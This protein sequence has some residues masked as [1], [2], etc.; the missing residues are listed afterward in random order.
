MGMFD[1]VIVDCPNCEG[2]VEFQSKAGVCE[3]ASFHITAV[4]LEIAQDINLDESTCDYCK[5]RFIISKIIDI[6]TLPMQL[7][8]VD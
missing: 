7:T 5:S 3:S 8:E 2:F 6:D 4:P 1:R